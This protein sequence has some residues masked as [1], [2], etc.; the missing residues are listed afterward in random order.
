MALEEKSQ[1][2]SARNIV[3]ALSAAVFLLAADQ[4]SKYL[5]QLYLKPVGT[6]TV[7]PGFLELSYLENTGAAFGLFQGAA[8]LLVLVTILASAA[9]L[10]MVFRYRAHS[11]FSLA[12]SALILAG[13]FGNLADRF[14]RGYVTDFF[15]VLFFDYIFNFADCCITVSVVLFLIHVLFFVKEP[16]GEEGPGAAG[17]K[18]EEFT[19]ETPLEEGK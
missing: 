8:W 10:V 13:G 1:V 9:I 11:F 6:V 4:I 15:H 2:H 14:F 17:E 12:A 5:V 16:A 19:Q 18:K 7:I 3:L